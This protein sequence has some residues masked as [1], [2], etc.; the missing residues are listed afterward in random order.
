MATSARNCF[1]AQTTRE[2]TS[3]S[4]AGPLALLT[5]HS[6]P[7]G[8]ASIGGSTIGWKS[9]P[10][11]RLPSAPSRCSHRES[12]PP[13]KASF[14]PSFLPLIHRT[15]ENPTVTLRPSEPLG[16]PET[17]FLEPKTARKWPISGTLT[18]LQLTLRSAIMLSVT[19]GRRGVP[20]SSLSLYYFP[21]A[22]FD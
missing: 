1:G 2:S 5:K 7:A 22:E 16:S 3:P 8:A 15:A 14:D 20:R 17:P 4:T 19:V 10:R 18:V 13:A 12:D 9:S 11:R 6:E 21:Y